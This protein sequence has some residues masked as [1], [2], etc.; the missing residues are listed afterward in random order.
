M[1]ELIILGS[2]GSI[3]LQTLDIVREFGDEFSVVGLSV[4][5][6][7]GKAKEVIKEFKPQI[8]VARSKED[9]EELEKEFNDIVILFGE[10]GLVQF[11]AQGSSDQYFHILIE[12]DGVYAMLHKQQFREE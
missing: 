1:I 12:K 6:N 5:S 9:K 4:G 10:E 7:L 11:E 2:C 8:V 3:G